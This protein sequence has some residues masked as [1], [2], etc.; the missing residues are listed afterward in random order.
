MTINRS[1]MRTGGA[2]EGIQR[3]ML[4]VYD[5]GIESGNE[6]LTMDHPMRELFISNDDMDNNLTF[7]VTGNDQLSLEFMLTPG[8]TFNERMPEFLTVTVT[9]PGAWRWYVRSGRVT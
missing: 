4:P 1:T 5:S 7:I 2:Y 8:G 3:P 6:V 9:A